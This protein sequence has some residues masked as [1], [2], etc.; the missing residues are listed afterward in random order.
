[1]HFVL[2]Y[3]S[4]DNTEP[5]ISIYNRGGPTLWVGGS[6]APVNFGKNVCV[7]VYISSITIYILI[8]TLKFKS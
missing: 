7:Y 2:T 3:K 8:G 6:L 1:M 4:I 5:N